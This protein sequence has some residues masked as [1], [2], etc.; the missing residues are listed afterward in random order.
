MSTNIGYS[1]EVYFIDPQDLYGL[2]DSKDASSFSNFYNDNVVV[3]LGNKALNQKDA[4]LCGR[5]IIK[6]ALKENKP[7]ITVRFAFYPSIP[8]YNIFAIFFKVLRKK[9]KF[10]N[11]KTYHT[12]LKKIKELGIERGVR[13]AENA[14]AISKR[15]HISKEERTRRYNKLVNSLNEKGF[16][17]NYPISIML[18]RRCGIKD[19]VDDGHHRIRVCVE[20]NID[21]IAIKF[22][23][24]GALPLT[25]QKLV[26]K[27][28]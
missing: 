12:S 11:E 4:L 17:D 24:A 13:T 21:R 19:S 28:I 14:Y 7:Y 15:W 8:I 6:S 3:L 22:K 10:E 9:F 26:L 16:D 18:C 25:I 2:P 5:N 1:S 23:A 27:L 20:H